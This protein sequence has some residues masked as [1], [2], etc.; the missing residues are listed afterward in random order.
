[1]SSRTGNSAAPAYH[2]EVDK[3]YYSLPCTLI[4]E[5]SH[6]GQVGR[7]MVKKFRGQAQWLR[8]RARGLVERLEW[9]YTLKHG[10]WLNMAES[11]LAIL[12]NQWLDLRIP[13]RVQP[14]RLAP[15][16]QHSQCQS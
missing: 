15:R 14:Q 2:A 7:G 13:D 10:S 8:A 9:H 5:L 1:M 3:H 11:E 6:I 16:P 12:S 4:L